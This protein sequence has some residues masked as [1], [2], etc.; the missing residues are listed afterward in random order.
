MG[1]AVPVTV[2]SAV[3]VNPKPQP[4]VSLTAPTTAPIAGVD[5]VFTASIA[6]PTGTGAVMA[7]S[8]VRLG[9]GSTRQSRRV[10]RTNHRADTSVANSGTYVQT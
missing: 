9:D 2:S 7:N 8:S 4:T 1:P 6:A 10:N 3:T 5:S